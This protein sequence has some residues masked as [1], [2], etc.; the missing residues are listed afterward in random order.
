MYTV[1]MYFFTFGKGF[2]TH[3]CINFDLFIFY[4]HRHLKS[5][6]SLKKNE[7]MGDGIEINGNKV[8]RFG[9]ICASR[10]RHYYK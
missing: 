2:R 10:F 3:E 6:G 1:L 5:L 8:W 7:N 9:F 4:M